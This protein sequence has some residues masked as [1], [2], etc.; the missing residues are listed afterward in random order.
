M[1]MAPVDRLHHA[2]PGSDWISLRGMHGALAWHPSAA[3]LALL[4]LGGVRW[5]CADRWRT[6]RE[7]A[8]RWWRSS[9]CCHCYWP[10]AL[11]RK[12]ASRW[13][14]DQLR[15]LVTRSGKLEVIDIGPVQAEA[16]KANLQ[17]CGG[18]DAD[19]AQKLG[20]ELS[21]T[22]T[23]QKV[24]NLILNINLYVPEAAQ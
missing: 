6:R 9:R 24:S 18:C 1:L 15:M 16:H 12:S 23:V 14:G 21:I 7:I 13:L 17:A 11:L 3:N 8:A 5:G 2:H 4:I 10:V 20:A 19:F 22:G